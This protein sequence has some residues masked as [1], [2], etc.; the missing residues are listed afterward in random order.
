M[1]MKK[2]LS[3]LL[4][5]SAL[6]TACAPSYTTLG[7]H[8]FA[9]AISDGAVQLVDVRTAGEFAEAH[10]PGAVNID[11]EGPAFTDSVQVRLDPGRPVA[12]YCRSGKRSADAAA[13]LTRAGFPQV[14]NL[15][16][17]ITAWI[18]DG[19]TVADDWDYIVFDGETAPDF[20]ME[21][22]D[23]GLS[24]EPDY[25]GGDGPKIR[26]SDLRGKVVLLQFTASWCGVCRNEM[27]HLESEIWQR[28]KDNPDFVFIGIDRDEPVSKMRRFKEVTGVTYPF[29]FDPEGGI[30]DLYALH[31]SGITRNVLID[32]EGAIVLRTRLYDEAAF[33][34]LV[35]KVG[36]LLAD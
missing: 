25:A 34:E 4:G 24:Y 1:N 8:D 17:G 23:D 36:D 30:F 9:D 14:L 13:K 21:L 27:P 10:I 26:L 3:G 2:I 33:A 6:L 19:R 11:V 5:L 32:K 16:G 28:H 12:V 15:E 31:D 20:E 18:A 35:G 22:M 29:A 7:P